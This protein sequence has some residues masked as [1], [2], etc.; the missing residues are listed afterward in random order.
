MD[1]TPVPPAKEK[2]KFYACE[3]CDAPL[4]GQWVTRDGGKIRNPVDDTNH[5]FNCAGLIEVA[6]IKKPVDWRFV[7]AV[8][9]LTPIVIRIL[10]YWR[11]WW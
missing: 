5:C 3:T 2:R 7:F 1:P 9:F 11:G 4:V 8:G 6:K 10:L